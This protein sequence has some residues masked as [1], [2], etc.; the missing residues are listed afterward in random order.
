MI[1]DSI[2]LHNFGVYKG[3]NEIVLTPTSTQRPVILLGGLNGGGKT[4]FLDALLLVLYGKFAAT[5]NRGNTGYE[6]YLRKCISRRVSPTDGASITLSFRH[7]E[8]GGEEEIEISRS[9]R[10]TGKGIREDIDVYRNG[11]ADPLTAERWYEF[12]EQLIPHRI[13]HLFFFDG[14]KIEN[15]ASTADAANLIQTGIYAL[16]GLDQ[17]DTLTTD[18]SVVERRKRAAAIE[19]K[20][21]K[22]VD[23]ITRALD[24][25]R[26]EIIDGRKK[27][28][29]LIK[30]LKEART[31]NKALN[32][33]FIEH[34][35][36]LYEERQDIR[37]EHERIRRE[38]ES[39]EASLRHLAAGAGPLLLVE[40]LLRSIVKQARVEQ[41]NSIDP[42]TIDLLKT[43]DKALEAFLH[44][45]DIPR[46][47]AIKDFLYSDLKFR[48]EASRAAEPLIEVAVEPIESLLDS[49]LRDALHEI[50]GSLR[51]LSNLKDQLAESDRKLA[52]I[53]DPDGLEGV[54]RELQ[55]NEKFRVIAEHK[56]EE[57]DKVLAAM[58]VR[59]SRLIADRSRLLE[60]DART[61]SRN[62]ISLRAASRCSGL[63]QIMSRF[64]AEMTARHLGKLEDLILEGYQALLRKGSLITKVQIDP[65]SFN[66]HLLDASAH[67]IPLDR[68][69]AGERQLLAVSILWG[70]GKASGHNT[71]PTVIDTPLGRLDGSHRLNLI[72]SY[73]PYASHQV[74]LLSTDKEIDE[75]YYKELEDSIGREYNI[76]YNDKEESSQITNGYFWKGAA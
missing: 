6:T 27:N 8:R 11:V 46:I 64:K 5:S 72:K 58:E 62:E 53:P 9:W 35:G 15:M 32:A 43:R 76:R 73:F 42:R 66:I 69:S 44:E 70:L 57:S 30:M 1:I 39:V 68:L 75:L 51:N 74:V 25:L 60:S 16:L 61:E 71:L 33:K 67:E 54:S 65:D 34:G 19:P 63:R 38:I 48:A 24:Q 50:S 41:A 7:R 18:L 2:A 36:D 31:R 14:E 40:D 37:S 3:R 55:D 10:A 56:I 45:I 22:K 4:T 29:D 59:M 17:I 12:I 49:S 23:E 52:M 13:A 20:N 28:D 21:R 26:T 47:D